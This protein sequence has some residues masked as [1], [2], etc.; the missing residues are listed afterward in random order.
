MLA[1]VRCYGTTDPHTVTCVRCHKSKIKC[2]SKGYPK[3]SARPRK[4]KR[5]TPA[6]K[7]PSVV[8]SDAEVLPSP[9]K[10][11]RAVTASSIPHAESSRAAAARNVSQ[12]ARSLRPISDLGVP[13]PPL[14][15]SPLSAPPARSL[16][17]VNLRL[18]TSPSPRIPRPPRTPWAPSQPSWALRRRTLRV[19][20]RSDALC[21]HA[22]PLSYPRN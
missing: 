2:S 3:P 10:R 22:R 11:Q 9:H 13:R 21:T 17:R 6:F 18:P 14:S 16:P 19:D 7:T 1:K 20:N 5:P 12:P 15:S 4:R 8:E